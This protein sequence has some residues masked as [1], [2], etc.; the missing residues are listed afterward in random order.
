MTWEE[1]RVLHSF[2]HHVA[3]CQCSMQ[4]ATI[5]NALYLFACKMLH[6]VKPLNN[7]FGDNFFVPCR[8]IALFSEIKNVL[9]L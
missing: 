9:K 2:K 4:F 6:T 1:R 8:E 7:V 5:Y 3:H